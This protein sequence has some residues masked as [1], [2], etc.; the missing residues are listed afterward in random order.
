MNQMM[1]Q[2][3]WTS[4]VN[5]FLKNIKNVLWSSNCRCRANFDRAECSSRE[6]PEDE[7]DPSLYSE[8]LSLISRVY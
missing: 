4:T 3:I 2:N 1:G 7:S 5:L 8:L 6:L